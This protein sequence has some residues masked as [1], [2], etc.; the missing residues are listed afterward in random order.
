M[1]QTASKK[2]SADK[3]H[4]LKLSAINK[5]LDGSVMR[6]MMGI[7]IIAVAK[8]LKANRMAA[9]HRSEED[10]LSIRFVKNG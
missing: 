5:G 2:S 7:M 1:T 8:S 10:S 6:Q 9:N 4:E 3:Y